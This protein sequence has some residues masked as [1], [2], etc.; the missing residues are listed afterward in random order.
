MA[1]VLKKPPIK[2][3][4]GA[5][6]LCFNKMDANNDWTE[7]FTD[8][9]IKSEVVKNVSV[10]ENVSN[11]KVYASGKAYLVLAKLNNDDITVE[12]IAF[13]AET[14][15]KMRGDAVDEGGLVMTGGSKSV[16]PYFAFGKVVKLNG[17]KLRLDWYPKC[18]LTEN[19]D[20]IA[21]SEDS[22]SE[23]TDKLT[24]SALPFDSEGHVSVYVE[25]GVN[26][27]SSLTEDKFFAK[28]LL[29]AADLATAAAG[30]AGA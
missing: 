9:V 19:T 23:Q 18:K 3:T 10:V 28:P 25:S 11:N 4:V 14:L 15:A 22:Y 30:G 16:R 21:T 2:E 5:L 7:T 12:T 1:I 8:E 17:D 20:E 13:D 24:I 6:Y 29:K 26:W 27:P